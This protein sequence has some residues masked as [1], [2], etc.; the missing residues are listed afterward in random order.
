MRPCKSLPQAKIV[1]D[2]FHVVKI[3]NEAEERIRKSFK[4]ELTPKVRRTLMHAVTRY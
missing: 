1:I 4:A 3:A 2:K